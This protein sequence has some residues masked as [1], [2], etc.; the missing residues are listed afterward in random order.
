MF[1]KF[2][3]QAKR[4]I[5]SAQD[6]AMALGHD[7]IGTEHILLGLANVDG[8]IASE[9]L[10]EKQATAP[11]VRDEVVRILRG[12]G[13][14][15]TSGTDAAAALA[16]IGIDVEGIKRRADE[17]FGPGRFRFPRPPFTA[18]AKRMLQISLREAVALGH[19]YVGT[20]HLLLGLLTEGEGVGIQAL[21]A[22]GVETD[23][24]RPAVLA[25]VEPRAS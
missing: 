17:S 8:G 24:L 4:A 10:S 12:A 20:E 13:V 2:T 18:R 15:Q 22:L 16:T 9:V 14:A 25:R 19:D 23:S 11:L 1:E 7:F 6:E 3:D 21:N 5:S